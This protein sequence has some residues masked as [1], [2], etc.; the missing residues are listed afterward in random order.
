MTDH[1]LTAHVY[2]DTNPPTVHYR[3]VPD[4]GPAKPLRDIDEATVFYRAG[5][6]VQ[7]RSTGTKWANWE[8]TY[9]HVDVYR[10]TDGGEWT[11]PPLFEGPCDCP[12]HSHAA[13]MSCNICRYRHG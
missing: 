4:A 2:H 8:P 10:H 5:W 7:S 1:P 9:Q 6:Q 11:Q 3:A 12:C 13:I